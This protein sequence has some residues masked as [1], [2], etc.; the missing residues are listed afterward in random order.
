MPH[1]ESRQLRKHYRTNRLRAREKRAAKFARMRQRKEE[2]R[3]ERLNAEPVMPDLSHC[4]L[5]RLKASGF[6]IT[7]Q[8]LDDGER[9]SF[10]TACTPWGLSISPTAC[11]AKVFTVLSEYFP[12]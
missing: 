4:P 10:T 6:R 11:A 8:C 5:P 3:I 2:L 7:I 12:A 1:V 9:S